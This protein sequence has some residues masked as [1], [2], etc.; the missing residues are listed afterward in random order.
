MQ[1]KQVPQLPNCPKKLK[2]TIAVWSEM[3][4][5]AVKYKCLSLGEGAPGYNPPEFLRN[6]M[7]EAIDEG[8][9]QYTRTFGHPILIKEIAKTYGPKVGK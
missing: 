9:N 7:I 6:F 2:D 8:F 3:N 5:A 4:E 1:N